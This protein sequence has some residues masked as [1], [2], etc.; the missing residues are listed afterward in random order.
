MRYEYQ[1]YIGEATFVEEDALFYG[2]VLHIRD[3]VT[4][5]AETAA[6]LP[7]AFQESVDDYLAFCAERGELPNVG[8]G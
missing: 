5:I 6:E 3:V 4:F 2:Q 7:R 1:G 8:S